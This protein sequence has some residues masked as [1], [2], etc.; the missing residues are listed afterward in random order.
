MASRRQQ[1]KDDK[2]GSS[3]D[4]RAR[5]TYMLNTFGDGTTVACVH[6]AKS[7][8]RETLQADR[9]VPGGSYRRENVQPACA[10]C[11]NARSNDITWV[12]PLAMLADAAQFVATCNHVTANV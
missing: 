8:T 3:A 6:C 1:T 12:G 9:I 4:R 2:R 7:L 10:K 11:N 5:K